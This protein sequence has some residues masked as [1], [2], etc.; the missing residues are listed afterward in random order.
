MKTVKEVSQITG[1]SI[2]TLHHY[3][4]I[5]LLKPTAVTEAGYRLYDDQALAR[6]Q[7]VLLFRQLRFPLKEIAEI[8]DRPGF[9]P[10]Q[11]LEDQIQLLEL[12]RSKLDEIIAHARSLQITGGI[13]MNFSAFDNSKQERYAQ[14]AKKKWGKTD[15]YREFE[16]KTKDQTKAQI[17]SAGDGLMDIFA[18]IGTLRHTSPESA[19]A[20]TL[21]EKLQQYITDHFYTCTPQILRGLGQMY[22]AGDELTKNIDRAGGEG[23]AEF[24]HRAIEIYCA[25]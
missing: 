19:G 1:I 3:D 25:K 6:L 24:T 20:Q 12:Q 22:I 18:E 8:L 13:S 7:T 2:R 15:A 23:T 4:A 17:Q 5:G 21:I 11:A 16:Q 9:D 10:L 14:E